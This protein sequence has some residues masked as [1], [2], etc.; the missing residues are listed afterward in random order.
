MAQHFF[1]LSRGTFPE[2]NVTVG[3]ADTGKEVQLVVVDSTA[4]RKEVE[5]LMKS[6]LAYFVSGLFDQV[7]GL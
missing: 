5:L 6:I 7:E 1:G 4:N 3:T 2:T